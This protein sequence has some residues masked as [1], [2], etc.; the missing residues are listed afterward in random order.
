MERSLGNRTGGGS[1]MGSLL[2]GSLLASVAGAFVGTAIADAFLGD[3]FGTADA[4]GGED[5]TAP[6]KATRSSTTQGFR[7]RAS[8]I[9][10]VSAAWTT[11]ASELQARS[12][13]RQDLPSGLGRVT[14]CAP[15]LTYA[16]RRC[17]GSSAAVACFAWRRRAVTA[18]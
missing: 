2:A 4:S 7:R 18:W 17:T 9:K 15:L 12:S 8:A 13:G 14:P 5:A 3:G 1:G 11:S 10:V 6:A 16:G